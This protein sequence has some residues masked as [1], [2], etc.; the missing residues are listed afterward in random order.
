MPL[1]LMQANILSLTKYASKPLIF[2][3]LTPGSLSSSASICALRLD[4]RLSVV[5]A[6]P[7]GFLDRV[8]P[9]SAVRMRHG[10]GQ[11]PV[12][13]REIVLPVQREDV[14]RKIARLRAVPA[15]QFCVRRKLR[16]H[17]IVGERIVGVTLGTI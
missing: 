17:F 5:I 11:L 15:G 3:A 4:A 9:A 7:G 14:R 6:G 12:Q 1:P 16:R 10:C 13:Q 2:R 8:E